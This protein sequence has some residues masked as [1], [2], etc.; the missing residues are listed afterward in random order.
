MANLRITRVRCP[1]C[2]NYKSSESA[3]LVCGQC[4]MKNVKPSSAPLM[5]DR[6]QYWPEHTYACTSDDRTCPKEEICRARLL[7][8]QRAWVLCEIPDEADLR[9]ASEEAVIEWDTWR[10]NGGSK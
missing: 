1:Q 8:D 5:H 7:V 10:L 3:Y 2:G 6:P 4:M 9:R